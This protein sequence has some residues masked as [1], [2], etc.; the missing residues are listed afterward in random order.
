MQTGSKPSVEVHYHWLSS[1]SCVLGYLWLI[2]GLNKLFSGDFPVRFDVFAR[3]EFVSEATYSWYLPFVQNVL[4]PN[5]G[6]FG[7]L[8]EWGELAIALLFLIGGIWLILSKSPIPHALV[9]IASL[10]SSLFIMNILAATGQ[11]IPLV[12][13]DRAFEEGL[14]ADSLVF[15]TSLI[16]FVGNL[17]ELVTAARLQKNT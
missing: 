8:I 9:M 5:S 1:I 7:Y 3:E 6:L 17:W 12:D 2:S 4:I 14:S 13:T 15:F 10:A 11:M 16:L